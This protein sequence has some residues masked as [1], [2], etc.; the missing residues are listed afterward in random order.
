MVGLEEMVMMVVEVVVERRIGRDLDYDE[1][2]EGARRDGRACWCGM[3][4]RLRRG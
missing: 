4:G 2:G 1:D 3:W